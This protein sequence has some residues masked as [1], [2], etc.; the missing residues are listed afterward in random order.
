MTAAML[1]AMQIEAM[2][3]DERERLIREIEQREEAEEGTTRDRDIHQPGVPALDVAGL[4]GHTVDSREMIWWG[5]VGML[6]IEGTILAL[7]IASYF[8]LRTF[9]P[10]FPSEQTRLPELRGATAELALF[11]ATLVPMALADRAAYHVRRGRTALWLA[12][13][14]AGA[15][16]ACAL[17][18]GTF[19]HLNTHWTSDAYGS[20]A[21]FLVGLQA[22]HLLTWMVESA[23]LL[24]LLL[25]GP[26]PL[27]LKYYLDVRMGAVFWYFVVGT[28]AAVYAVV[29]WGPRLI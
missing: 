3:K 8:Y 11:L 27:P 21:W 15:L 18:V 25:A 23:A 19:N 16:V 26:K 24:A 10:A 9:V 5:N 6:V 7:T 14:L 13:V 22:F 2:P 20:I 12:V 4:G 29:F 28:W 17:R 1:R